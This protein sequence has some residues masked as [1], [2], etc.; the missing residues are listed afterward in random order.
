[1]STLMLAGIRDILVITNPDEANMYQ[2]LLGDGKQWGIGLSY[3]LQAKPEGIAQA[4]LIGESFIG[5]D[6]VC[7]MLGDNILHGDKLIPRLQQIAAQ[8]KGNTIFGYYVADPERYG[9]IQ[10]DEEDKPIDII[11]KPGTFISHYAV[12]GLYFYDHDVIEVAKRLKPSARG[13]LE[14]SDINKDYLLKN[15]L[16]VEK[17]GRGVAWLDTGTHKSLLDADNFIYVLEQRQGLKIG[18]P[19]ESAWRM[20]YI[21]TDQFSELARQQ[22]KSGYGAYLLNLINQP[23]DFTL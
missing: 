8:P 11:E 18:S 22:I 6:R 14:I 10:F 19:E 4:L 23:A 5:N 1:L 9:V 21:D 20:N 12:I 17:L 13:E 16:A 2:N 15:K 7:L 3:A